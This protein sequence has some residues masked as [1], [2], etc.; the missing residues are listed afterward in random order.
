MSNAA[1][2]ATE[3]PDRS[4]ASVACGDHHGRQR[5]LGG[6]A[7]LA[8]RGRPSPRRRG[9]APGGSRRPRTRHSLSDDLLL[10]LGKLVASGD[11]NRRSVRPAAALHPQRSCDLASRRRPGAGDRRARRTGAGH[12]RAA[13]RGGRAD[14]GQHQAQSRG[15]VQL[16]IAAGNRATPR[17]GSRARSPRASAILPRSMPTRSAN[18][19]M[20]PI[21]P[22]PI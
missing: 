15:R 1:A 19:S 9:V 17:S 5:T 13:E 21:F 3:G 14:Q 7:R 6:G 18:T 20:R 16:R 4:D 11:R 2:P 8:A 12:L 22:I 10:Q